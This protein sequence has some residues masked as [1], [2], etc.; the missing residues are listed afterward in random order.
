MGPVTLETTDLEPQDGMRP[1][2]SLTGW[3]EMRLMFVTSVIM[4]D[5]TQRGLS[6]DPVRLSTILMDLESQMI[7]SPGPKGQEQATSV[8][9]APAVVA[10]SLWA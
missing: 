4:D 6:L 7:T 3:A 5:R 2:L 8:L 1:F 10:P 9:S